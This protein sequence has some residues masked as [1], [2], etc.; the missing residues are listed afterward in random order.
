MT[1]DDKLALV[2]TALKARRDA[3]PTV[4]ELPAEQRKR[5]NSDAVRAY[6][7]R[8]KE[9]LQKGS[10]EPTKA[11]IRD[12]LAD[13]AIAI[14]ATNSAGSDEIKKVL[15]SIFRDKPGVPMTTAQHAKSG[16]LKTKLLKVGVDY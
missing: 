6:R 4:R 8:Q 15:S 2:Y 7:K 3:N 14:L 9:A 12:A 11:N 16:K 13:A 10:P 1:P 5:Y